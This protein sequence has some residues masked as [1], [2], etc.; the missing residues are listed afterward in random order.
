MRKLIYTLFLCAGFVASSLGLGH[1]EGQANTAV[2]EG[3][4]QKR[5]EASDGLLVFSD[6]LE[7]QAPETLVAAHY[8]HK[9]HSSHTSHRSHYS[10]RY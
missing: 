2:P 9:S 5:A 4:P 3:T 1:Q 10:S 7:Q 8:S 6:V